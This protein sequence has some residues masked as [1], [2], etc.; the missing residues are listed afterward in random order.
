MPKA[1]AVHE[2]KGYCAT[3]YKREFKKVPCE[4]CGKTMRTLGGLGPSICKS[5]RTK[6]RT[7]VRC[8]KDVPQA[9]LSVEGGV[10][11][12]SCTRHFKEPEACPACGQLSLYLARDF[13]NGFTVPVCQQ[14]RRK[15]HITCPC[16]GK[17][18]RPAGSTSDGRLVCEKCLETDG[19]PFICPK[20][21]KAG[22]RHS[23][24][25]CWDC[26]WTD[27]VADKMRSSASLLT[28]PWTKDAFASFIP[29]LSDRI[30]AGELSMRIERH[31]L[32]FAKLDAAFRTPA[33]ATAPAMV[34]AF[35]LDGL[36]R[37]ASAYGFLKK[38]GIIPQQQAEELSAAA[39][40]VTQERLVAS[41]ASEWHHGLIAGFYAHL[42][43]LS[44]RY[45]QRGWV[46]KRMRFGHRTVTAALRAAVKFVTSLGG[47]RVSS[48]QQIEQ[49][50]LDRFI[51]D[52]RGYMN[53]VR[54]FVRYLN[55]TQKLFR[56]L[57]IDSV[58]RNLPRS[59]LLGNDKYT[60]LVREWLNPSDETLK[61]SIIC[62]LMLLYAQRANRI[63]RLRLSDV[64]RGNDGV[65]RILFGKTEIALDQRVGALFDRYLAVRKSLATMEDA[66]ENDYLFTGRAPGHHLKEASVSYYLK[67]YG[68][69]AE[70]MF[71]TSLYNAYLSGLRH[72]KIL[73]KAFGIT[74][75]TA[76]KYMNLINSRMRDELEER[77][78]ANG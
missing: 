52:N 40:L 47:M 58:S 48:V 73:V 13:R 10:A 70:Q 1:H 3:C 8:G 24:T 51:M 41:C 23:A 22:K 7:C 60:L 76:V 5:C 29:A 15:G 28:R 33:D 32:F 78:A 50:Q 64:S 63:V 56:K 11:C 26:Y 27:R 43:Q 59:I 34:E 19:K 38:E 36:R 9:G 16:C 67:K 18:R 57:K 4:R 37:H 31:F 55:K 45:E 49:V 25:R 46:G 20:C 6:D 74:N 17:H 12:P 14:C 65:Y 54:A 30:N 53:G 66:W 39:A 77:L 61:E 21:G 68:V 35:G 71:S 42:C 2:G 69:T 44:K 72:P 75:I 62:L